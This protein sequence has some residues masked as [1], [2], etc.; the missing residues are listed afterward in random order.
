MPAHPRPERPSLSDYA[1]MAA[2]GF[3][4]GAVGYVVL[5]I[6]IGFARYGFVIGAWR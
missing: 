3:A 6:V 4:A 5:T 1:A 2:I